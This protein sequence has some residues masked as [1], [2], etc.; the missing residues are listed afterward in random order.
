MYTKYEQWLNEANVNIIEPSEIENWCEEMR[1]ENYIINDEGG[2]DVEG[3]SGVWLYNKNFKELPYKFD[4]VD[5]DF[6]LRDKK[7]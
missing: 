5:G 4:N 2:I 6:V 7:I 3:G 1:I